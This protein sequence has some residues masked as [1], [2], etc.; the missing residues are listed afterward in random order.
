MHFFGQAIGQIHN[1]YA[2]ILA[3]MYTHTRAEARKT[4]TH[5][6]FKTRILQLIIVAFL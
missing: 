2:H 3:N 6:D 5:S 4:H 1:P